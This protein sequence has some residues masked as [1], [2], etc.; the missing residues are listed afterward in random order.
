MGRETRDEN[1]A[2]GS[3]LRLRLSSTMQQRKIFVMIVA[4]TGNN[5][6]GVVW[7]YDLRIRVVFV[8]DVVKDTPRKKSYEFLNRYC[9]TCTSRNKSY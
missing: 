8:V 5:S 4:G 7:K 1:A 2:A 6:Q 9:C 3:E